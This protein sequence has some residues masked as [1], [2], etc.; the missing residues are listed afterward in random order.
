MSIIQNTC[1]QTHAIV[2]SS[3]IIAAHLTVSLRAGRPYVVFGMFKWV[4]GG[5]SLQ[6][7]GRIFSFG[8]LDLEWDG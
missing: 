3:T 1:N 2:I 6:V 5:L 8:S 4:V 7:G